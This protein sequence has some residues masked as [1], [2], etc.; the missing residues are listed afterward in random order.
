MDKSQTLWN[1]LYVL[2]YNIVRLMKYHKFNNVTAR[3]YFNFD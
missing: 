2:H 1:V 3:S